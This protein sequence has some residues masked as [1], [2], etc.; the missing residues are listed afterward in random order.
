MR[1]VENEERGKLSTIN[2]NK[3][4]HFQFPIPHSLFPI[5]VIV[6]SMRVKNKACVIWI[7]T[8]NL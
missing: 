8:N 4:K 2:L 1:S 7:L 6:I 3:K 5:P